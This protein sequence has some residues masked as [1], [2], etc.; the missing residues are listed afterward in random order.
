MGDHDLRPDATFEEAIV[1]PV[2]LLADGDA[3]RGEILERRPMPLFLFDVA[4]MHL[5]DELVLALHRHARLS[6]VG[7]VRAD[8]VLLQGREDGLHARLDLRR[9]VAGAIACEQE[10]QDEGRDVGALL[11]PV[12]EV[13][14]DDLAVERRVQLGVASGF[15]PHTPARWQ[16][17]SLATGLLSNLRFGLGPKWPPSGQSHATQRCL[18]MPPNGLDNGGLL[19]YFSVDFSAQCERQFHSLRALCECRGQNFSSPI[20]RPR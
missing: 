10:L 2:K 13:L 17:R 9:V 19:Q 18:S 15:F 5:V 14:A 7:L 12:Q 4:H 1:V 3:L 8:V 20:L 16:G 6:R 11:D